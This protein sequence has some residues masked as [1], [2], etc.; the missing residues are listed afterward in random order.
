MSKR[1]S[2]RGRQPLLTRN[3]LRD[4]LKFKK[5]NGLTNAETAAHFGFGVNTIYNTMNRYKGAK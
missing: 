1:A 4:V 3:K 2:K 5:T